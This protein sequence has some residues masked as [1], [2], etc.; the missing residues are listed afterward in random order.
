ML[1]WQIALLFFA[2]IAVALIHGAV[3]LT[4]LSN[5]FH[6]SLLK[7]SSIVLGIFLLIQM[8]YFFIV[9]HFYIGQVKS[10]LR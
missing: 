4:T 3:A 1:N 7:E 2:P 10:A 6:Y 5:M 9:R 8:V